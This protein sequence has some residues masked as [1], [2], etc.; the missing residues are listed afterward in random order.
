MPET[1]A[2]P[3]IVNRSG[4]TAS[5]L[6]DK[7]EVTLQQA[8]EQAG[9]AADIHLAEGKDIAA[10][11]ER[12]KGAPVVAVGGGDGTQGSA[13]AILAG[14]GSAQLV[15]PLGTRNHLAKQLG[16]PEDLPEA[17]RVAATGRREAI[18][19]ATAGDRIF[20]N[21]ASIG[22]YT[23]LV[24]ERDKRSR[25][26]WLGTIPA[27][28]TVL[29]TLRPRSLALVVDGR[30]E[31]AV[32]P[33]L[34]IGNNRYSLD[35]GE[36]GRRESLSDGVL[37]LYAVAQRRP[38]SLIGFALRALAGRADPHRDFGALVEVRE[39]TIDGAGPIEVA[40]DGEV[41]RMTLP[42]TFRIMPAA[43]D[44]LVPGPASDGRKP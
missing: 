26:K 23:R 25:S 7:L 27:A 33:M 31:R 9:V 30:A 10:A 1:P 34:F 3:V 39:V 36:V 14:S 2:L 18:D 13:A 21:N 40:F 37:S 17:A 5:R 38:L 41:E 22:I 11:V 42:L 16:M 20:V 6:G 24:R 28:W 4:G 35:L 8:F 19:L 43:L 32:T 12:A 44:V 29:S 15:L